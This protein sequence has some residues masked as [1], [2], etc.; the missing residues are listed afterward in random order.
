MT[1]IGFSILASIVL[2][3]LQGSLLQVAVALSGE[4]APH[5]GK[6]MKMWLVAGLLAGLASFGWAIT[7]GWL[8]GKAVTA[9][10]AFLLQVGVATLVYR[11]SL[12]VSMLQAL[13]VSMIQAVLSTVLSSVVFFLIG[14]L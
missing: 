4:V 14:H 1:T 8:F 11:R 9:V 13:I 7:F 12:N 5:Y 6:A 10:A 2:F 3:F